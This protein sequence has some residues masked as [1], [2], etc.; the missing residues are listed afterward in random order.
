M[1]RHLFLFLL[2]WLPTV[3]IGEIR[4]VFGSSC[5]ARATDILV[6]ETQAGNEGTFQVVEVWH[7]PLKK[8]AVVTVPGLAEVAEGKMVL[9]LISD[10]KK[11]QAEDWKP[12]ALNFQTSVVWVN[13]DEFTAIQQ[14]HSRGPAYKTTIGYLP[15]VD[16]LRERVQMILESKRLLKAVEDAELIKEK[17]AICSRIINGNYLYK[18]KAVSLLA[19]CGEP[20]VPVLRQYVNS[21]PISH[22]RVQ[23]IPAFLE[24]AGRPVLIELAEMLEVELAYWI[25][26][27]PDLERGWWLDSSGQEWVRHS[28]VSKLAVVFS[29]HPHPPALP[30]LVSLR[31]L[32][33]KTPAVE[34]DDRI[35][36]ISKLLDTAIASQK[37]SD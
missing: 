16:A 23:A 6:V 17:V 35:G 5:A 1:M 36:R 9:F 8:D 29:E 7:G 30:T 31:D 34:D 25:K 32:F 2:L 3:A 26:T 21:K 24:A 22:Q 10:S 12:T 20:A 13:G 4:P 11:R 37:T 33:R 19:K 28:R 14:P 18:D 15:T 27:A